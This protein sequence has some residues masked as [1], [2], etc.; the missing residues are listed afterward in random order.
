[1][2]CILKA[3]A[4]QCG[5]CS[6]TGAAVQKRITD[7]DDVWGLVVYVTDDEHVKERDQ[8]MR[9]GST[10]PQSLCLHQTLLVMHVPGLIADAYNCRQLLDSSSR[11]WTVTIFCPRWPCS[12][13]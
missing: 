9:S 3:P 4:D 8:H 12:G 5:V 10:M 2:P 6:D 11:G 7:D 1:M 13:F